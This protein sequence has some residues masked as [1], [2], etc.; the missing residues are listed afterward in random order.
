MG[1]K[2]TMDITRDEAIR[3]IVDRAYSC[4]DGE[5]SEALEALGFGDNTS[6][7]YCGYNFNVVDRLDNEE[8][9]RF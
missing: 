5:L 3:L 1:W 8:E 2:S 4:T 7:P 9:V 6:L